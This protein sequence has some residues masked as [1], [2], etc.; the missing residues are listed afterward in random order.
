M[1]IVTEEKCAGCGFCQ[2]IC[3]RNA[4]R[5]WGFARI[6]RDRCTECFEGM[7]RFEKNEPPIDR[8]KLL[9]PGQESWEYACVA[10]C[11]AG[12]LS[13]EG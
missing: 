12:A 2:M 11:P 1:V 5:L 7:H 13:R 8:E 6:D 10:N 3:P 9:K 4:M